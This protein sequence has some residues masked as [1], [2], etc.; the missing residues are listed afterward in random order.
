M[1]TLEMLVRGENAR[2]VFNKYYAQV[3]LE[4]VHPGNLGALPPAPS[5]VFCKL[6]GLELVDS[7][8]QWVGLYL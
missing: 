7:H 4:L 5:A 2:Y 6:C 8:H 3:G 1:P